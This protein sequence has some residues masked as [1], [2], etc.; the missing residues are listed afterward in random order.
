MDEDILNENI[1]RERL[2]RSDLRAE[3]VIM[4]TGSLSCKSF[5][6]RYDSVCW[7]NDC[8]F[9]PLFF[10][11]K[12]LIKTMTHLKQYILAV[13]KERQPDSDK[14]RTDTTFEFMLILFLQTISS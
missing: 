14:R 4:N 13:W 2:T 9:V 8:S 5:V 3:F 11:H 12:Q 1:K 7:S 10:F 6:P